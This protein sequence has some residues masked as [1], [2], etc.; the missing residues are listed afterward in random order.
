MK[1]DRTK[2]DY[3]MD[4]GKIQAY[5]DEEFV[6]PIRDPLWKNIYLSRGLKE[7]I[8]S[9]PF[10]QLSAIRQLGPTYLVY[11][12]ATHTRL[13]HSL[14]VL[15]I[16]R[17]I[18]YRLLLYEDCPPLSLEGVRAFLGAC[19]LHDLGH[20]PYAHSLKELPL[21]DHEVLTSE[22]IQDEPLRSILSKKAGSDPET[23]ASIVDTAMETSNREVH[24]F[25]NILSGVLDP[26]KLDY[27]NRDA[28]FCGVPYG[29]QDTDFVITKMRPHRK[30]LSLA[31]QGIPAVENILFSKYLMFR[32]VY[33]HRVVRSAAAMIKKAI[34]FGLKEG[35]ISPE[36]LYGLTDLT[37]TK[38]F[39]GKRFP[40]H[41]LIQG[42]ADRRLFKSAWEIPFDPSRPEQETLLSLE[43]RF[44]KES[45][46][47]GMLRDRGIEAR[48]EEIIIDIPEGINF[49]IA[50]P[51]ITEEGEFPF[52]GFPSVFTPPVVERFTK[53][54]RK[55]RLFTAPHL[56]GKL[57]PPE[58]ILG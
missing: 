13:N 38:R 21:K 26:D 19:L 22:I 41:R 44:A 7:V 42:A 9:L 28:Y 25:R 52:S 48:P 50:L 23:V 46:I 33:W 14:G 47:A 53:N 34:Y 24:F 8:H 18:L 12:G 1:I 54:L 5:L 55:L 56:A 15:H 57:P 51:I 31:A 40:Y 27:L 30:G 35:R 16:G 43:S 3:N 58:D 39:G 49:E 32:T 2:E 20:Y 29:I 6:E 45:A 17:R 10:Q 11:P 37:F 4:R 36:E